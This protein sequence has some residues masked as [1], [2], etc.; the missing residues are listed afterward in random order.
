MSNVEH[1]E[2]PGSG[3]TRRSF[4]ISLAAAAS[5]AVAGYFLVR[6]GSEEPS[7]PNG[8]AGTHRPR[9]ADGVT[10]GED[11]GAVTLARGEGADATVCG[12]N[13]VGA[14]ILDRLDGE[15]TVGDIA[16]TLSRRLDQPRTDAMDAGIAVFVARLGQMGFLREPFHAMVIERYLDEAD[17]TG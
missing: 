17:G 12:V 13:G 6:E 10:F 3:W 7:R 5:A 4:A 9:L 15:H 11:R 14:A 2:R 8:E 16:A 1:R